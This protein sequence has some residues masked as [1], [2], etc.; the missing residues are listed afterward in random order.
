MT[1]SMALRNTN[2]I[3]LAVNVSLAAWKFIRPTHARDCTDGR[4]PSIAPPGG[5]HAECFKECE[6]CFALF[7][8]LLLPGHTRGRARPFG[9]RGKRL[10][11]CLSLSVI[12]AWLRISRE[13]RGALIPLC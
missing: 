1:C 11:E 9:C 13:V 12:T 8:K 7:V 3:G 4:S 5:W 10:H 2:S 6:P